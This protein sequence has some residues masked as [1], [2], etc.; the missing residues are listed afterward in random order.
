MEDGSG[1]DQLQGAPMI[2]I[3]FRNNR[4]EE[5]CQNITDL[6]TL[7]GSF[8][9]RMKQYL[10]SRLYLDIEIIQTAKDERQ[11]E[12]YLNPRLY[13][14][15]RESEVQRQKK[16]AAIRE[17][18]E[19]S[20]EEIEEL[21]D[22]IYQPKSGI[23]LDICAK[24]SI[25]YVCPYDYENYTFDINYRKS[26]E[27]MLETCVHE[28]IHFFWFPVW[29]DLF[30]TKCNAQQD[31][32]AWKL[33]ELAIDALFKETE[34]KKYCVSE[35]PAHQCFYEIEIEGMSLVEIFRHMFKQNDLKSFMKQGYEFF[36][37][38]EAILE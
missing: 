9:N 21:L 38:H 22:C 3:N 6:L 30:G 27:E 8:H 28:L 13:T 17:K 15:Y 25:N 23:D 10:C 19:D 31:P 4:F 1:N 37:S 20:K 7:K 34:L 12:N 14:L 11:I 2:K 18:W 35:T 24:L 5:E 29:E 16:L 36:K 33:S 26:T 32:L